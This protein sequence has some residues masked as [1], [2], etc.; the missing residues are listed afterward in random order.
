ME[1]RNIKRG[2]DLQNRL[3]QSELGQRFQ[4]AF[5]WWRGGNLNKNSLFFIFAIFV[6][7]LFLVYP[8]FSRDVTV[9]FSSSALLI[10]ADLFDRLGILHKSQFFSIIV[11][12]SL[13]FAPISY[14]LFVRKVALRHELTAFLASLLFILPTPFFKDG[15]PMLGAILNGDGAHA[16]IFAFIPLFL[17][18]MQA[19]I[20][21]GLPAWG[22][23][24]SIGTAIIAIISPFAFFNLLI[25]FMVITVAE[26]F[27]G[28]LRIKLAR[29]LF[30]VFS[31]LALSFFWYYP[32]VTMKIVAMVHV[33]FAI[34]K[35]WSVFPLLIPVI[36][37]LGVLSFL[38]FDKREK[39]KPIFIGMALFLIY[40]FLFTVSKILNITGI[41]IA[42]RY[43]IGL[44]FAA[45]FFFAVIFVLLAELA[46]RNYI[47]TIKNNLILFAVVFSTSSLIV[48]LLAES[49]D[50]IK[51]VQTEI[52]T[53]PIL[54][55]SSFG[56]GAI[57]RSFN[58][59]NIPS[60]L[61]VLVSLITFI[62]LLII[63]G[64]FS[65]LGRV[66]ELAP[67]ISSKQET[68]KE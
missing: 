33:N 6:I 11:F 30:L 28:G 38:I 61:A 19:F 7:N 49:L 56:I 63:L 8:L 48:F 52:A 54:N 68:K 46:V 5:V 66:R 39:L 25:I 59:S 32:N 35:F 45:S 26:G 58:F 15:M 12:F 51:R 22:V 55:A 3:L 40:F 21:T 2:I 47:L 42:E 17:L 4:S 27:L 62:L 60:V 37:I 41:F 36:P 53:K 57:Q 1:N 34:Q 29:F 43:L 16:L 44:S 64:R 65:S 20:A 9:S 18:Y 10:I 24:S 13:S 23:M 67:Y 31:S 50:S 14:Y